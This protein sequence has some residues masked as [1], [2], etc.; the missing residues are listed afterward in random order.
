MMIL[1]NYCTEFIIPLVMVS[2]TLMIIVYKISIW[3]A[4]KL[5]L[6]ILNCELFTTV[7]FKR[8]GS[9]HIHKEID[10]S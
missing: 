10:I 8:L 6:W 9:R 3:S 4:L 5:R 7:H 2:I 1:N